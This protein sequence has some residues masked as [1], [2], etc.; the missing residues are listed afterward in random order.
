MFICHVYSGRELPQIFYF[1]FIFSELL[2]FLW[3]NKL[4]FFPVDISAA[5]NSDQF[6]SQKLSTARDFNGIMVTN[7][8]HD[9]CFWRCWLVFLKRDIFLYWR[10]NY[11]Y[12]IDYCGDVFLVWVLLSNWRQC[13]YST[14]SI[15]TGVLLG[16]KNSPWVKKRHVLSLEYVRFNPK[17]KRET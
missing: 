10:E 15:A 16:I 11:I 8:L 7:L 4:V 1:S 5:L 2:W 14:I 6:F 9:S 17:E 3:K 13:W 12:I